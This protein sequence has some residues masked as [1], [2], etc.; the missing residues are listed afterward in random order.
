MFKTPVALISWELTLMLYGCVELS[1]NK[2]L[3]GG[4]PMDGKIDETNLQ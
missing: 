4:R 3:D 2:N 1:M